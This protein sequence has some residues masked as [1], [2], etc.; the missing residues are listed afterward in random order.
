MSEQ[1]TRTVD[2]ANPG[3]ASLC[4][5]FHVIFTLLSSL[6]GLFISFQL[7][8]QDIFFQA[9][10]QTL[11]QFAAMPAYPDAQTGMVAVL[12]TWG[13]TLTLH[14]H[15]HCIV[16]DGG[17]DSSGQ[18][19]RGKKTAGRSHFLFPV[20]P[21]ARVFHGKSLCLMSKILKN[22]PGCRIPSVRGKHFNI[23]IQPPFREIDHLISYPGRYTHKTAIGNHRIRNIDSRGV[24]FSYN[25]YRDK[26]CIKE[27]FLTGEEFLRRFCLHIQQKGFSKIRY[28]GI[29]AASSRRR[30]N[31]VR[32][33][34]GPVPVQPHKK[35]NR[36]EDVR[37]IRKYNPCLCPECKEGIKATLERIFPPGRPPPRM[38]QT[39]ISRTHL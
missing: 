24:V 12:Y 11:E 27:M 28:F 10:G 1:G 16:P 3:D 18:W 8:M 15:L 13:Q 22:K 9:A 29:F 20:I 36:K 39:D 34:S 33:A 5:Y 31:F 32:F 4:R 35:K 19:I 7:E 25:D 17:I 37:E 14:L 23:N 21:M 30:L 26:A 2:A 38:T 6:N